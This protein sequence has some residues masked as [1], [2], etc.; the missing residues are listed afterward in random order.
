MIDIFN[1]FLFSL[2]S[3][4]LNLFD[5]FSLWHVFS[6]KMIFFDLIFIYSISLQSDKTI[7]SENGNRY[8]FIIYYAVNG[9]D[10]MNSGERLRVGS[11]E[12]AFSKSAV[13]SL[14]IKRVEVTLVEPINSPILS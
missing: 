6:D 2:S 8:V 12:G 9:D 5:K 4:V 11:P 13:L 7:D 10:S 3:S 14:E 1:L